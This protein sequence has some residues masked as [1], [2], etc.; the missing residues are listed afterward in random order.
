MSIGVRSYLREFDVTTHH[1]QLQQ[2]EWDLTEMAAGVVRRTVDL[3]AV[4]GGKKDQLAE[5]GE[6]LETLQIE[7]R[8][9]LVLVSVGVGKALAEGKR[10]GVMVYPSADDR[11]LKLLPKLRAVTVSDV[12]RQL[13]HLC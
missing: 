12:D 5:T 7:A 10:G 13:W 8:K 6:P 3:H 2:I 9:E 4:A 11:H 1:Q